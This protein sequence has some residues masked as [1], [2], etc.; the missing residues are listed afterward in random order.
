MDGLNRLI[1]QSKKNANKFFVEK[2]NTQYEQIYAT[3][4]SAYLAKRRIS[5]YSHTCEPV[6]WYTVTSTTYNY[7]KSYGALSVAD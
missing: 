3:I 5:I 1:V 4:L 6:G 7:L 2:S